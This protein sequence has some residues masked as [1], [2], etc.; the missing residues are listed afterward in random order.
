MPKRAIILHGWKGVPEGAW[1]PW[2]KKE[3]EEKWFD[4]TV[5]Q[6]PNADTPQVDEWV[7]HISGVVGTPGKDTYLVGHSL[8]CIA[9]LR[10]LESLKKGQ[11]IGGAVL[12]AGSIDD[13]GHKELSNFFSKPIDWEKIKSICKK[14]IAINSDNDP[15]V[16]LMHADVFKNRLGA[17]I[18]IKHGMKHFCGEDGITELPV[19]LESVLTISCSQQ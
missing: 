15:H 13:L 8:G 7:K 6:L 4:V 16:P 11:E 14:V 2:L 18:I 9:I 17:E 12:V 3:L 10:Y 1:R 19:A 5:P